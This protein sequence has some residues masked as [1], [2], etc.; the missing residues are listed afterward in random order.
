MS[1]I[2][3]P[4]S[5]RAY[6]RS[7]SFSVFISIMA[8]RVAWN[9]IKNRYKCI[10][11]F[12]F[13]SIKNKKKLRT[14]TAHSV[15]AHVKRRE[16]ISV[17][18]ALCCADKLSS[19]ILCVCVCCVSVNLF[20][21]PHFE[22]WAQEVLWCE[23]QSHKCSGMQAREWDSEWEPDW[24]KKYTKNKLFDKISNM[25]F[26]IKIFRIFLNT[27]FFSVNLFF[28]RPEGFYVYIDFVVVACSLADFYCTS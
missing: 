11:M 17:P 8:G 10:F 28:I 1:F 7:Q 5:A 21:I 19:Y 20:P 24:R 18:F 12:N 26:Q 23:Y 13:H 15:A 4:L 14:H 27:F 3:M 2:P 9:L 6:F 16:C 22:H 25:I